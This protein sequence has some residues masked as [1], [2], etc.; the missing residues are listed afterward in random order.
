MRERCHHAH[1]KNGSQI[2][3]WIIQAHNTFVELF[4]YLLPVFLGILF[5]SRQTLVKWSNH[6]LGQAGHDIIKYVQH[7]EQT[8]SN[9][10][11]VIASKCSQVTCE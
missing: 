9:T 8:Q 2:R 7:T 4:V 11:I 5:F 3:F 6:E 10:D 1:E